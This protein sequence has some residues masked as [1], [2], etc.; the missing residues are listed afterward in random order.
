MRGKTIVVGASRSL[1]P[2]MEQDAPTALTHHILWDRLLGYG[3]LGIQKRYKLFVGDYR[4]IKYK[5]EAKSCF[6]ETKS[7]HASTLYFVNCDYFG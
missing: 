2:N 7:T 5:V 4:Q 6:Y 1:F 3:L